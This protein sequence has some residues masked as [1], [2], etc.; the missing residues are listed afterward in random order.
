LC[1]YEKLKEG[2][3]AGRISTE[4]YQNVLKFWK[5]N[6][7]SKEVNE[8]VDLVSVTAPAAPAGDQVRPCGCVVRT[9]LCS[10]DLYSSVP[11]SQDNGTP[12]TEWILVLSG[13]GSKYVCFVPSNVSEEEY[14]RSKVFVVEYPPT[15]FTVVGYFDFRD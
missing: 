13:Y 12:N 5:D 4:T 8:L 10:H 9:R 7:V 6:L 3:D 2:Y 15:P 1:C 11:R 14:H